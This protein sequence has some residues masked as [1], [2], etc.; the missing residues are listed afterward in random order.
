MQNKPQNKPQN[1]PQSQ[2]RQPAV[3]AAHLDA[4]H[5]TPM[6]AERI[7]RNL[8][9]QTDDVVAWCKAQITD[10]NCNITRVGKNWYCEHA[11]AAAR[12]TVN[13]TSYTIITAHRLK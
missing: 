2:T 8:G 6:G 3:L 10:P 13:A 4:L 5:T 7:R 12:I 11:G 1:N 9:L